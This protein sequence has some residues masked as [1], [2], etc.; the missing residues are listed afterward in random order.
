MCADTLIDARP[1]VF[2]NRR[3]SA[4][5]RIELPLSRTGRASRCL[6]ARGGLGA[7]FAAVATVQVLT[8]D[9]GHDAVADDGEDVA[10][11]CEVAQIAMLKE[12]LEASIE[13][14][15]RILVA[16]VGRVQE[17]AREAINVGVNQHQIT[18]DTARG[19][20]GDLLG[21]RA[22]VRIEKRRRIPVLVNCP[23]DPPFR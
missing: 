12:A 7:S 11:V 2:C 8:T 22:G 15:V 1:R 21:R 6:S 9:R 17:L 13:R 20:G 10:V 19:R 16:A 18:T 14:P 23:G 4:T 5:R 3:R